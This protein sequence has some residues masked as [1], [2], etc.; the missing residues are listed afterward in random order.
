MSQ[1]KVVIIDDDDVYRQKTR[2]LLKDAD[3][4]TF[5]GEAKDGREALALIRKARP[6]VTLL[7]VGTLHASTPQVAARIGELFSRIKIIVLNKN[8]Q[9]HLV[10][11]A[12]G[13]GAL[14]HLVKGE[15]RPAQIV[16]AIR[17]VS[18]GKAILSP[19]VAGCM[20]DEVFQKQRL[21]RDP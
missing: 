10:L 20:L 16:D 15:T 4:I 18:R 12:L 9:E 5:A 17:A 13:K 7:D 14:G 8:S 21:K 2:E 19:G 11:S 1:I 6:D 3:G